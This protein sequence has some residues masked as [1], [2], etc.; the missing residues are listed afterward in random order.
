MTYI[1]NLHKV[2]RALDYII[3]LEKSPIVKYR[4]RETYV[5]PEIYQSVMT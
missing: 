5:F 2:V 4:T 1:A 3:G